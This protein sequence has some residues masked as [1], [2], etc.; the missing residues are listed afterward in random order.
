[1]TENAWFCGKCGTGNLSED[2]FCVGCGAPRR[3]APGMPAAQ[4][5]AIRPNGRDDP[6]QSVLT[7]ADFHDAHAGAL[8]TRRDFPESVLTEANLHDAQAEYYRVKSLQ[9][10]TQI[11]QPRQSTLAV[12]A[13]LCAI[14]GLIAVFVIGPGAILPEA[15]AVVLGHLALGEVRHGEGR[16]SGGGMAV[17][18]LVIGYFSLGVGAL[19]IA[20]LI[21]ALQ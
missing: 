16:I 12:L 13:V 11:V 21:Y 18:A 10:A 7:E 20:G 2:A 17:A 4:A 1:M 14:G 3:Q 8:S 9:V 5:S 19:A 6:D 15:A